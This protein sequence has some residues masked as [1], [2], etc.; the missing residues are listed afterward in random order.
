MDAKPKPR[1]RGQRL[2]L[3]VLVLLVVGLLLH[4][5]PIVVFLWQKSRGTRFEPIATR[6]A[7]ANFGSTRPVEVALARY[8]IVE[9]QPVEDVIAKHGPF[10]VSRFG[11]YVTLEPV[12]MANAVMAFESYQ[13][14][15]K[16]GRLRTAAW[17]TCTGNLTFFNSLSPDD[18]AD[19]VAARTN[20][21]RERGLAR[22]AAQMAIAGGGFHEHVLSIPQPDPAR[23]ARLAVAGAGAYIEPFTAIRHEDE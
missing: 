5:P 17:W 20:Y 14:I 1:R 9:G 6:W 13:I 10:H 7:L 2:L 18:E 12:S 11:P 21:R 23:D 3:A 8:R 15:A 4:F 22:L 19:F 16:D